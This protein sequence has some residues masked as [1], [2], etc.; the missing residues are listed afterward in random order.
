MMQKLLFLK[1]KHDRG[2]GIYKSLKREQKTQNN[3][4]ESHGGVA[5][6]EP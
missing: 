1:L 6:K 2:F 4:H 5:W 3:K